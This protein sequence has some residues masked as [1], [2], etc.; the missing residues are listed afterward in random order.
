VPFL[1]VGLSSWWLKLV[2]RIDFS[3][4]RELVLGFTGDLLPRD[5]RYWREIEYWP[6]WSF[7]D[8]AQRAL[9]SEVMEFSVRGVAGRIEEAMVQFVSPKY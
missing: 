3:L 4:A 2:T 5:R 8:A 7:V 6:R 9:Q 1:S